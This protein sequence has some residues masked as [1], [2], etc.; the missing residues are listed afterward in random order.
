VTEPP[1][2]TP[3][4]TD[5]ATD[6]PAEPELRC[7]RCSAPRDRFQE[8]CLECGARLVPL[9]PGTGWRR[10]V[11]T[12]DSPFWFWATFLALLL[13]VLAAGAIVLAATRDE[14]GGPRRNA[15]AGPTTSQLTEIP[16]TPPVTTTTLPP[17]ITIPPTTTVPPVTTAPTTTAPPPPPSPPPPAANGSGA[18]IDWPQGRSGYTIIL[19]SVPAGRGRGAAETEARKAIDDG[20]DEV[21]VL[22]SSNFSSLNTGYWVVFT[23]VYDTEAGARADL[24]TVRQNGYPI[25]Y[26]REIT[27]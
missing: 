12:R 15:G 1:A 14:G 7:W 3:P 9:T 27:P 19:R 21:G 2:G 18:I 6:R 20:L 16:T 24:P 8:Y 22:S 11:W 4:P 13:I 10:E 23:G 25:A 26:I 5:D 17:E